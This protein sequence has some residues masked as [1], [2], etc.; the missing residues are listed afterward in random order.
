MLTLKGHKDTIPSIS[1][2]PDGKRMISGSSDKTTRQWDLEAGKEIEEERDICEQEVR[3]VGV[4]RD[5][6]WV[7]SAGE[8]FN[9]GVLKV[10]EVETGIVR[11]FEGHSWRINC[12]DI[13]EDSTLLASG[14]SDKTVRI[15]NLETG[16]LVAGPIKGLRVDA[17]RFSHDS[18]KL[19]VKS[20]LGRYLEVWDIQTQ[21]LD[22]KA[23]Q[24]GDVGIT[25]T[26]VFWTTRDKT[27]VA[28]FSSVHQP[29]P[30]TISEFDSSTLETVGAPFEGHNKI[31]I[32]LALSF[33]CA[34]IAS[35]SDDNTIKLWAFESRHLLASFDV[36]YVRHLIL[37]PDSRQLV[38]TTLP[39]D[40]IY[41]CKT[42]PEIFAS[43]QPVPQARVRD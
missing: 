14:A 33:D 24:F 31:I 27:I 26:S 30:N 23:G 10:R 38:Y 13:S 22:I 41:L 36:M 3:S 20:W 7:V 6:R 34:F 1:Y 21:R 2:F 28:A 12:I 19:A 35:A 40:N 9:T 39:N 25:S 8:N 18:K 5:G 16:K 43:T 37:S 29:Y 11:I 42:P 15:W 17:I 32:D 4:S